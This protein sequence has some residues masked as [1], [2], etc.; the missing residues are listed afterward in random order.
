MNVAAGIDDRAAVEQLLAAAGLPIADLGTARDLRFRVIRDG[1]RVV[2][3][4][5]LERF[6]AV[7]LLR[8]LVVAPDLRGRGLGGTLVDAAE[9]DARAAGLDMLV[10]LTQTAETFFA[11]RGYVRIDRAAAPEAV[12]RSEEF[13]SLCPASA[14]T[15]IKPLR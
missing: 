5:G 9:R 10:L 11:R 1:G 3:A 8:S 4:I 7:G 15:M 14:T 12:R 2:G 13:A 6:G